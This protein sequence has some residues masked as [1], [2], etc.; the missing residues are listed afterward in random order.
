MITLEDDHFSMWQEFIKKHHTRH[1]INLDTGKVY[2]EKEGFKM[3]PNFYL[4]REFF[5]YF[6]HFIDAEYKT[7]MRHLIGCTQ[8]WTKVFSRSLFLKP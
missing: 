2:K 4:N 5:K 7:Y 8:G 6:G 1:L 3:S